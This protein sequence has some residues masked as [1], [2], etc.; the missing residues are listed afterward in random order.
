M[1]LDPRAAGIGHLWKRIV[2]VSLCACL[3]MAGTALGAKNEF[4]S[5]S[6]SE[7]KQLRKL[8]KDRR[9]V[10]VLADGSNLVGRVEKVRD[11]LVF[12]DMQES[13]R[14]NTVKSRLQEIPT[15]QIATMHFTRYRGKWRV[16]L[17]TLFSFGGFLLGMA[18]I[19]DC[20]GCQDGEMGVLAGIWGGMTV[21][22]GLLG[23]KKDK[24][25]VT[26]EIK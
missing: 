4:L 11:G 17:A 14:S 15:D 7:T 19:G 22:G 25:A 9:I 21:L 18:I 5:V 2:A 8:I 20:E 23:L 16:G 12:L 1:Q 24:K 13:T 3:P 6:A 10:A 26:L